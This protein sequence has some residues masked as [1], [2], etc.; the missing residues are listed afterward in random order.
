MT[1]AQKALGQNNAQ[2]FIV[3]P[4]WRVSGKVHTIGAAIQDANSKGITNKVFFNSQ[5]R[6]VDRLLDPNVNIEGKAN[7]ARAFFSP[8]PENQ[9]WLDNFIRDGAKD[10]DTGQTVKNGRDTVLKTLYGPAITK[11]MV[12]LRDKHSADGQQL[13][14]MYKDSAETSVGRLV[15][16][17]DIES[18]N[19]LAAESANPRI[20]GRG[21][22]I[23]L[24]W[25]PE[26]NRLKVGYPAPVGRFTK[27]Q[28]LAQRNRYE[29]PVNR[30]NAGLGYLTDIA[31]ASGEDMG[32]YMAGVLLKSGVQVPQ[33]EPRTP[34]ETLLRSIIQS[35]FKKAKGE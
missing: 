28:V 12:Q 19:A 16:K 33:G 3:Q 21:A 17:E 35:K 10:P 24:E 15:I 32:E 6:E 4:D 25:D 9:T 22:D 13:W 11:A 7:A 5:I 20:S 18:L 14:D 30:I 29:A 8:T 31:N 34:G 27:E 23:R 2:N 26:A 1:Q